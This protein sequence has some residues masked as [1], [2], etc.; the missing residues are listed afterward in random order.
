MRHNDK[1]YALSQ[2]EKAFALDTLDPVILINLASITNQMGRGDE[3][4]EYYERILK[5]K[6]TTYH[7]IASYYLERIKWGH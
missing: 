3:A 4:M 7:K 6:D 1:R 2:F 5:L